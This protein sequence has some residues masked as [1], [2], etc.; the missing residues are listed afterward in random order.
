M[1]CRIIVR[2][3]HST[4]CT[5]YSNI[6]IA[7]AILQGA[8]IVLLPASWGRLDV[9]PLTCRVVCGIHYTQHRTHTYSRFLSR[10]IRADEESILCAVIVVIAAAAILYVIF[11]ENGRRKSKWMREWESVCDIVRERERERKRAGERDVYH[12]YYNYIMYVL[13]I[14]LFFTCWIFIT[15]YQ[16]I[17]V[18]NSFK[19]FITFSLSICHLQYRRSIRRHTINL[20]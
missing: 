16:H 2:G 3:L 9:F 6:F 13:S 18:I 14:R 17:G 19:Y 5:G 10:E 15:L 4:R 20:V 7:V 11:R 8:V 12:V 1:A